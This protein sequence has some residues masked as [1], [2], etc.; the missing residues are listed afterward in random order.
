MGFAAAYRAAPFK[1]PPTGSPTSPIRLGCACAAPF[2]AIDKPGRYAAGLPTA[3]LLE[4]SPAA[5][6]NRSPQN[7]LAN[8]ENVST[9]SR[10]LIERR[11][12]ATVKSLLG[13]S[14]AV[15]LLGP[16]QVGKTTLA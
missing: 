2:S 5:D 13:D 16:R 14:P 9:I 4:V 15:A 7:N 12:T 1:M 3:G 10:M 11:I 8:R 6:R